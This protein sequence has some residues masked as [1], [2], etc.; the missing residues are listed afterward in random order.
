MDSQKYCRINIAFLEPKKLSSA[1][2][3]YH[4]QDLQ[5]DA[6]YLG[7]RFNPTSLRKS[8]AI[9]SVELAF[10][11]MAMAKHE[12]RKHYGEVDFFVCEF[13]AP[14]DYMRSIIDTDSRTLASF[15][16]QHLYENRPRAVPRPSMAQKI[17]NTILNI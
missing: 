4:Q 14:N 8:A 13:H 15:L 6:L 16:Q 17:R 12:L 10:Q 3:K 2:V 7:L 11:Y 5:A 9:N 1:F